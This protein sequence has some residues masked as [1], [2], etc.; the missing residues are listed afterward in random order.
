MDWISIL[1]LVILIFYAASGLRQGLIRQVIHIFGIVLALLLAF[2]YFDDVGSIVA[3][4]VPI[5]AGISGV[6][7]F[8]VIILAVLVIASLIGH[9]WSRLARM[10]PLS[11]LDA[12]GGA[13]FGLLKGLILVCITLVLISALPFSGIRSA[14]DGSAIASG[15]LSYAPTLYSRIER[16]LPADAPRLMITPEGIRLRRID[17]QKLD[18]ATCVA[19]GGKVRFVG[20]V[21]RGYLSAPK[22]VCARCGR[23]SDGCQT[24]QGFHLIYDKC[25]VDEAKKGFRI[26]CKVWPNNR[27]VSPRGPCPVC[28]ATLDRR[29]L[30]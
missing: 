10:T 5:S 11:M 3:Q 4:Y 12:V 18:G 30:R 15:I 8:A 19:C 13:A 21:Q 25:P 27:F 28:G 1:I 22:F 17:F 23:T 20:I 14:I 6:V 16:S 24:Y 2:R 29:N 7:G 26:D 9:L